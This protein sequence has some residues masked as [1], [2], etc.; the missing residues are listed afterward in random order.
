MFKQSDV[1][2]LA[3]ECGKIAGLPFVRE[4][5]EHIF[6][7]VS[8]IDI[9]NEG[10]KLV[11]RPAGRYV[12]VAFGNLSELCEDAFCEI[13][14]KTAA[15]LEALVARF[16]KEQPKILVA[17]LGNREITHDSLGARVCAALE[18]DENLA[19][20]EVGVSGKSGI[21][22]AEIIKSVADC[23][24]AELVIAVD[25]FAALGEE[26]V[27]RVIQLSDGGIAPGSGVGKDVAAVGS[28]T[29]GVP[30]IS[31]GVPTALVDE[32]LRARGYLSVGEDVLTV[33]QKAADIISKSIKELSKNL[34]RN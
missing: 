23:C 34:N 9:D 26:R 21:E 15:E 7:G 30:I 17:G 12:S 24:G 16:G 32:K 14:E 13:T 28:E 18:P 1:C 8:R 6:C 22:S 33:C 29:V 3:C 4:N 25:S 31:V 27:G 5:E 10:S 2:H 19:V 11:G 20:F